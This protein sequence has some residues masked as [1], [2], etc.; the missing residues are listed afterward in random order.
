M[1]QP[2]STQ[3][4][5]DPEYI[6]SVVVFYG[7]RPGDYSGSRA[8]HLG[9]FAETDEFEPQSDVDELEAALRRADRPVSFHRYLGHG[10][11][12]L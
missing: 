2:M 5:G 4:D 1:K 3:P 8:A 9:H 10:T 12:V 7:T 6:R 11:M